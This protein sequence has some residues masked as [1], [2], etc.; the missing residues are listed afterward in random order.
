VMLPT[1]AFNESEAACSAFFET[2]TGT[3]G[4]HSCRPKQPDAAGSCQDGFP[5]GIGLAITNYYTAA[6]PLEPPGK[7]SQ[8]GSRLLRNDGFENGNL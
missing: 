8:R 5:L 7:R 1:G 3:H 2:H 4:L 6:R